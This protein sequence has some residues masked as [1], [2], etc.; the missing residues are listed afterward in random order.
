MT[1]HPWSR[2]KMSKHCHYM[3]PLLKQSRLQPQSDLIIL[4]TS[5][6][7][8]IFLAV[9]LITFQAPEWICFPGILVIF[10]LLSRLHACN[11]WCICF[12]GWISLL[13]MSNLGIRFHWKLKPRERTALWCH[14]PSVGVNITFSVRSSTENKILDLRLEQEP[15]NFIPSSAASLLHQPRAF[16]FL[17]TLQHDTIL[18]LKY[19]NLEPSVKIF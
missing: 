2:L 17:F 4:V 14:F 12:R 15:W 19:K 1:D 10:K 9:V 11:H 7:Q 16:L 5:C 18:S 6:S 13:S 3:Y 8:L